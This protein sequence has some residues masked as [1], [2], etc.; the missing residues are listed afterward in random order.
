MLG[1]YAREREKSQNKKT[2]AVTTAAKCNSDQLL[3]N[4]I[5]HMLSCPP[6][7]WSSK[8]KWKVAADWSIGIDMRQVLQLCKGINIQLPA[9]RRRLQI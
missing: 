5:A 7:I 2:V 9:P 6:T 4:R 1:V 8:L 3:I